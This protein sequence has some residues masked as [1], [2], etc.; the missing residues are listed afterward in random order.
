M[1]VQI[2]GAHQFESNEERLTSLLIDGTL[3]IDAGSLTSGLSLSQQ[4]QIESILLTHHHFD[5]TRDLVTMAANA[6]YCWQRQL[7][8]YA[9]QATL[10]VV[11]PCLLDGKVYVNFFEYPS[12]AK[13]TILVETIEP[14]NKKVISGYD[15]LAVQM[16]H[17]APTVGYQITSSDGKSLFY[18]GDTTIGIFDCWQHVSPQLIITELTGLNE[19]E[20]WL[21]K[22]GHLSA[23]MLK[24]ELIQFHRVKGYF[25]RVICVHIG[26]PYEQQIKEEVAQ[27]AEELQADINL[28]HED[29]KITL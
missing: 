10:D 5:H 19:Q 28:G 20:D 2:L 24:E 23:R 1:E 12:K 13:P 27:V 25:P 18:T 7:K 16:K 11:I 22:V 15:V 29:M 14:Y 21:K 3:A 26:N 17:S 9:M 8:V 4:Q 6:T